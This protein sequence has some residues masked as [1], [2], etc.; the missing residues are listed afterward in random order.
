MNNPNTNPN[1]SRLAVISEDLLPFLR[2]LVDLHYRQRKMMMLCT[3]RLADGLPAFPSQNEEM[4]NHYA[5]AKDEEFIYTTYTL[6]EVERVRSLI[7]G[8]QATLKLLREEPASS[9]LN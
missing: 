3:Q 4:M 5:F 6:D 1:Q 8:S 9:A 2:D 7:S